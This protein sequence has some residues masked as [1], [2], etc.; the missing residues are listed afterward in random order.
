MYRTLSLQPIPNESKLY[1]RYKRDHPYFKLRPLKEEVMY[2][3]P[4]VAVYY[5]IVTESEM[6]TIRRLAKERLHRSGIFDE[7]E[8]AEYRIS[9]RYIVTSLFVN[10][11]R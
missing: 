1:C 9:K 5:D 2:F 7:N 6:T 4:F 8:G 3:E 11:L 10:N